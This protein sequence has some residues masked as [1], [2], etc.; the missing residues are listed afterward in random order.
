VTTPLV[1]IC[2]IC[3][4]EDG[5]AA[6]DSGA[7]FIGLVFADSKRRVDEQQAAEIV[8]AV[9]RRNLDIRF[10][11]VF[12]NEDPVVIGRIAE[13]VGLDLI[14]FHGDETG[15]TISRV[16]RPSIKAV[17]V[18]NQVMDLDPDTGADWL[19]FDTWVD[20]AK[21]GTGRT[22]DWSLLSAQTVSR[23]FFLSGGLDPRNV[24]LAVE[25]VNPDAV[26]VSSGV[27]DEPGVKNHNKIERFIRQVKR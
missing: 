11:G 7:D 22:F 6:A 2:G 12:V 13:D 23:R 16:A 25:T 1:K 15:E 26:D 4:P 8:E 17:R 19:L 10:V 21:G 27:E 14:Q 18:G 5:V 3:R 20:G 24:R 9:R